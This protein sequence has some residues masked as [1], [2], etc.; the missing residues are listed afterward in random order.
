MTVVALG[1]LSDNNTGKASG[2]PG[3]TANLSSN[4]SPLTSRR[5]TKSQQQGLQQPAVCLFM[6]TTK[7]QRRRVLPG[8]FIYTNNHNRTHS[9][10]QD[11]A[12]TKHQLQPRLGVQHASHCGMSAGS[13]P[14][15]SHIW[16]VYLLQKVFRNTHTHMHSPNG[17]NMPFTKYVCMFDEL[18]R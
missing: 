8:T 12:P 15:L 9:P 13:K 2:E 10:P 14:L 17:Q 7:N 11:P 18:G 5:M 16:N 1:M 6:S 3:L 4:P